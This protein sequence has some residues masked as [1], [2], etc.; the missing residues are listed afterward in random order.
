VAADLISRACIR[1]QISKRRQ[2]GLILHADIGSAWP[3]ASRRVARRSTPADPLPAR[4]RPASARC[5]MSRPAN[6][7][8][9]AGHDR[10]AAGSN[11]TLSG[12]MNRQKPRQSMRSYSF[13]RWPE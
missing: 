7:I 2:R 5:S 12:S 1:E 8:P 11:L 3:Q 10:F 4:R 13:C 6:A 9:D